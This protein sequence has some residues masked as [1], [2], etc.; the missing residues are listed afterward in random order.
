[1]GTLSCTT[2]FTVDTIEWL[3]GSGVVRVRDNVT[4]MLNLTFTPINDAIG[5]QYTCRVTN[6]GQIF[7]KIL[8]I[9]ASST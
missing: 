8:P 4:T 1:M 7:D 6:D 5:L 9:N 3:D 2:D